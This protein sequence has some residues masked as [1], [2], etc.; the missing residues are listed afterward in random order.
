MIDPKALTVERAA[1]LIDDVIHTVERP[2]RH[3]NIIRDLVERGFPTPI[4]GEQGF[5]L[6][7]GRFVRRKP[8]LRIARDAGQIIHEHAP[9]HGLFSEDVW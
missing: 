7:D 6:S 2:G 8:A 1:I 9:Q 3:H 4:M 5:Q